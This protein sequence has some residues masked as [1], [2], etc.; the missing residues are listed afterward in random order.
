MEKILAFLNG[1]P[2][3]DSTKTAF[4][5]LLAEVKA[6]VKE[7]TPVGKALV[8]ALEQASSRNSAIYNESDANDRLMATMSI[9]EALRMLKE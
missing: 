9:R 3:E 1:I 7:Q 2:D 5:E 8:K 4:M 6:A